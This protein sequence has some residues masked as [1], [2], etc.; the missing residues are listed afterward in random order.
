MPLDAMLMEYVVQDHVTIFALL[1]YGCVGRCDRKPAALLSGSSRRRAFPFEA[2]Q[3][4]RYEQMR[5]RFEKQEFL[6]IMIPAMM[7]PPFPVKMFELAAGVFEM[8]PAMVLLGYLSWQ[9]CS[10]FEVWAIIT[11]TMVLRFCIRLRRRYHQDLACHGVQRSI[12][13][14]VVYVLRKVFDRRR[15]TS[16][17]L[18]RT[19]LSV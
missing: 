3:S 13:L 14:L 7:P 1:F 15:G 2:H 17:R 12:V 4:A 16:F 5:D 11:I 8:K 18:K 6:A 19:R 10:L 9:I